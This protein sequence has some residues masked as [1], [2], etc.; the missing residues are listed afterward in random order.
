MKTMSHLAAS[1]SPFEATFL[2]VYLLCLTAPLRSKHQHAQNH[3]VFGTTLN[4]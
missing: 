4:N 3:C 1:A 2:Y